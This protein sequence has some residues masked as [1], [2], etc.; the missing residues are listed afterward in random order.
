LVADRKHLTTKTMKLT[1]GSGSGP[2]MKV[3]MVMAELNKWNKDDPNTSKLIEFSNKGHKTEEML[4]K[5]PRGQVPVL[6][7]DNGTVIC[8]SNAAC[9]YLDHMYNKGQLMLQGTKQFPEV[10]Q[11]MYESSNINSNVIEPIL[12]YKF[13]T[14]PEDV[15]QEFLKSKFDAADKE[16]S[17]WNSYLEKDKSFLVGGQFSMADVF[18]FVSI[19]ILERQGV[20]FKNLYPNLY[21]Y[22]ESMKSRSCAKAALPPHWKDSEGPRLMAD[23][24]PER[25]QAKA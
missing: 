17:L 21:A 8:E 6:E 24:K 1:W 14:K 5:N 2:C 20:D 25:G 22:N 10:L 4:K 11:R 23:Y 13:R 16:L 7:D 19:M 3:I 15:D 18:L 12:Y 9:E